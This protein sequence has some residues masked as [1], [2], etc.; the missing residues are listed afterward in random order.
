VFAN[1]HPNV[2]VSVAELLL[3]RIDE[4]LAGRVDVAFTRLLPGQIDVELEVIA[5]E[6]LV[7]ALPRGHP[8]AGRSQLQ[9]KD[10]RQERF[11]TNP[12]VEAST[13]PQRWLAEQTRHGLPGRVAEKAASVQ[14]I[15]TLVAA[16]RGVCL[17]PASVAALYPRTDVTYLEVTDAD[18]AVVS[19]AWQRASRRPTVDSFIE[20]ARQAAAAPGAAST[21]TAP[22]D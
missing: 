12:V 18:P 21:T 19:L 20:L 16:G 2:E 7:V 6:P 17:V 1:K 5:R 11:I 13:P 10:L 9:F 3:N 22:V 4:L 14:E 8:L 15:L